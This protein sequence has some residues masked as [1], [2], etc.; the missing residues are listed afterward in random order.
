[1]T[2]AFTPVTN[3]ES[4]LLIHRNWLHVKRLNS[5]ESQKSLQ[6][7]SSFTFYFERRWLL[8]RQ[9]K[10]CFNAQIV[11]QKA[12]HSNWTSPC[13]LV[14]IGI[15]S[16]ALVITKSKNECCHKCLMLDL[17]SGLDR[18]QSFF[19]ILTS[20]KEY[21]SLAGSTSLGVNLKSCRHYSDQWY[22][23]SIFQ[24]TLHIHLLIKFLLHHNFYWPS[25]IYLWS[26][27]LQLSVNLQI[28]W[29]FSW[30]K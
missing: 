20:G 25:G 21:H 22:M 2:L 5:E 17:L 9:A 13:R 10:I 7:L 28:V 26:P 29:Y 1:M 27:C 18:S 23:V 4:V 15:Y 12:N 11:F 16:I 14:I 30:A 3:H 6:I 8:T 19:L 24:V